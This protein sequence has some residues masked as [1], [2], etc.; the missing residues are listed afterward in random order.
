MSS[1]TLKTKTGNLL[2]QSSKQKQLSNNTFT[3]TKDSNTVINNS[4]VFDNEMVTLNNEESFFDSY[5]LQ[6]YPANISE[7][8]LFKKNP[9]LFFEAQT[10]QKHTTLQESDF[11][12]FQIF[13]S[14]DWILGVLLV[15]IILFTF[16]KLFFNKYLGQTLKSLYNYNDAQKLFK[17]QNSFSKRI[18]ILISVIFIINS[19]LLFSYILEFFNIDLLKGYGFL[20]HVL[21]SAIILSVYFFKSIILNILGFVFKAPKA[22]SEYI[23][24]IFLYNRGIGILLLPIIIFIPFVENLYVK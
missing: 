14:T 22:F 4:I 24:Q 17:D 6:F 8:E 20:T 18:S 10:E 21:L 15:S 11:N 12:D 5:S 9:F 16:T 2:P 3:N 1:Q 23:Y 13:K 19:A 7:A